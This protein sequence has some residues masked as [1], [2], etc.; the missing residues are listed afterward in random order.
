MAAKAYWLKNGKFKMSPDRLFADPETVTAE[1]AGSA[2]ARQRW[3][4]PAPHGGARFVPPAP[5]AALGSRRRR[6]R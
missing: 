3:Q 6:A 5:V 1:P 2:R 4:W